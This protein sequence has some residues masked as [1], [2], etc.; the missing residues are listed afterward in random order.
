M[1]VFLNQLSDSEL[2]HHLAGWTSLYGKLQR[3]HRRWNRGSS[4]I[5]G[6]GGTEVILKTVGLFKKQC[7]IWLFVT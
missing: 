2:G 1:V 6:D 3:V 5:F 7:T 4:N